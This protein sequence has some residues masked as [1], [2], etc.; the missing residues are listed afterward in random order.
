MSENRG[1]LAGKVVLV[2]GAS[3]GIGAA[4]ARVFAEEGAAL[5]LTARREDRLAE[6]AGE[7]A[8]GGAQVAQLAGEITDGAHVAATVALAVGRFG[9]LDGAFNN[10]GTGAN[11]V[12]LHLMD[13]EV[14]DTLMDVNARGVWLCLKHQIAAMLE[15]G[16]GAIVNT[17]SVAGVVATPVAAPYVASKHAVVGLTRAAAVEY[18]K[19]GIRVNAVLPGLTRTELVEEWFARYPGIEQQLQQAA[20]QSRT[21]DPAEVAQAAAWLLS[22]RSSFV[23]GAAVPVDGGATTI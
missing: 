4:A 19:H 15:T 7:L 10:A 11:P 20:P 14:Y 6:L 12:P 9:R 22:D 13:D 23:T 8:A 3:S 1:L 16:G 18:A 17:S 2:T 21:A 5:V